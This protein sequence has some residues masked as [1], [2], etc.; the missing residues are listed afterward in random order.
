MKGAVCPSLRASSV[1]FSDVNR[2][3]RREN[4]DF[5]S[6]LSMDWSQ[7]PGWI[8]FKAL[9]RYC[10]KIGHCCSSLAVSTSK[11]RLCCLRHASAFLSGHPPQICFPDKKRGTFVHSPSMC[12]VG[13]VSGPG[14]LG[15]RR[16]GWVLPRSAVPCHHPRDA[17]V[18]AQGQLVRPEP[19]MQGGA[20]SLR[21]A[22][23]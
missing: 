22:G 7:P 4:T 16:L 9:L 15:K 11:T 1:L 5:S 19:F 6:Q 2:Q 8:S 20:V 14:A 12:E 17:G 23:L 21:G 3:F 10:V 18:P 13:D